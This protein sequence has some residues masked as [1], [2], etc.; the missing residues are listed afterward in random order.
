MPPEALGLTAGQK[1]VPPIP[2]P[3]GFRWLATDDPT[4]RATSSMD[5]E[6][7]AALPGAAPAGCVD[8]LD[9]LLDSGEAIAVPI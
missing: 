9:G 8:A 6:Y 4:C 5:D 7:A 1:T 2:N 3:G